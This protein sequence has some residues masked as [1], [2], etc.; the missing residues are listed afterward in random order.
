MAEL[1]RQVQELLSWKRT[2]ESVARQ[3]ESLERK[4]DDV[5]RACENRCTEFS[6][7]TDQALKG[8]AKQSALEKLSRDVEQLKVREATTRTHLASRPGTRES[9]SARKTG[10][11]SHKRASHKPLQ[12]SV[13]TARPMKIDVKTLTGRLLKLEVEPTDTIEDLKAQIYAEERIPPDQQRLVF[14][15]RWLE[16]GNTLQYYSIEEG[17]TVDLMLRLYG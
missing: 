5:A 15:G 7:K 6:Q 3:F 12:A 16:E 11:S 4:V 13:S 2:M 17:S 1:Q 14:E 10:E 8:L 9:A